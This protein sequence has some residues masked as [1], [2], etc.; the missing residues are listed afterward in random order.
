MKITVRYFALLRERLG[1]ES[2]EL[3]WEDAE[4]TVER[5]RR[6]LAERSPAEAAI[7]RGGSLLVAV[8]REYAAA[9]VRLKDGDEVA[10][11]PPVTGGQGESTVPLADKV[12][13][14]R[15]PFDTAAELERLKAVSRRIG[16]VVLFVGVVRDFSQGHGVTKILFEHFPDMAEAK[17]AELR[18]AAIR[19]FG[20]I[21]LV[22][23][24]RVGELAPG[25]DIV[26]IAAAAEH[27]AAAFDGCSWCIDELKKSVPIWKK[28][29]AP[30]GA[31]WLEAHP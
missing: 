10:L 11:F 19:R 25:D 1:R 22:L 21:D 12:R 5:L 4:P 9:A 27:R 8:N 14:Q 30:D 16:G 20:L 13:V 3:S 17:L 15:E 28:E 29:H 24:H 7:L 2:E 26:L 6:H 23:V 31:V 18:D